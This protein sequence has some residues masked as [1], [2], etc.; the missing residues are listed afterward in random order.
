MTASLLLA[1]MLMSPFADATQEAYASQDVATLR[2]L[3]DRADTREESLLARYRLY[4]LTEDEN[5]IDDIPSDVDDVENASARELALLSGLWAYRAG[6][7]GF[8]FNAIRYG[9][10][11]V[12]FLEAA[13]AKDDT[14]PYV[15]LVEGQSYLFRPDVA[16]KDVD[17]AATLFRTLVDELLDD[18]SIGISPVEAKSWLWL[19][20]RE[21]GRA[22]EAQSL[23]QEVLS[24]DVAP[25]YRQFLNDPPSV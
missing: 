15:L 12:N 18:T 23:H 8:F 6:E 19:A 22:D 9:R 11:S 5:V 2:S 1:L 13:K 14:D 21:C 17:R 20:L 24:G 10:R 7:A 4:P 16:G 25:L 3:L